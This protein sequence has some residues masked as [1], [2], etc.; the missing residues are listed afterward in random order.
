MKIYN[1][2][3]HEITLF[4][5]EDIDFSDSRRLKIKEGAT[6]CYVIE[7][8]TVEGELNCDKVNPPVSSDFPFP[9]V[10]TLS[11]T[12]FDPVPQGYDLVICSALYRNAVA[13]LGGDTSK[14]GVV[15]GMVYAS[16]PTVKAPV[17]CLEIAIG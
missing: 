9:V 4:N 3:R 8:G 11:F 5:K 14:L 10:G 17:G 13:T 16:D 15:N 7:K 2:T 1:G 6:P 12:A